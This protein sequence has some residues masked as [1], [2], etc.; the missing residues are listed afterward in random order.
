MRS[1]LVV[2]T[3][4]VKVSKTK[5]QLDFSEC[6]LTGPGATSVNGLCVCDTKEFSVLSDENKCVCQTG[7]ELSEDGKSCDIICASNEVKEVGNKGKSLKY[8]SLLNDYILYSL[9]VQHVSLTFVF[10]L[11]L[12]IT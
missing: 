9:S 12:K 5:S 1:L 7:Y 6:S 2:S 10:Q 3:V 11:C 8:K 4:K